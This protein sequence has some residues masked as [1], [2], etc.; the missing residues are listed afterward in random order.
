MRNL[1]FILCL[2]LMPSIVSAG[3]Y[4][5]LE[6]EFFSNGLLYCII[7]NNSVSVLGRGGLLDYSGDIVVPETVEYQGKE[8]KVKKMENDAF[9]SYP[10]IK[11]VYIGR[12][13]SEIDNFWFNFGYSDNLVSVKVDPNNEKYDSREDC[14]AIIETATNELI[15]GCP[16]TKIVSSIKTISSNAFLGVNKLKKIIIPEGVE[17]IKTNSFLFCNDLESISISKTVNSIGNYLFAKCNNLTSIIIDPDNPYYDSRDNCNA[18]INKQKNELV[19]GCYNSFIP[20][21]VK[22]ICSDA[23]HDCIKLEKIVI[24]NSVE[25]IEMQAFMGC[26]NLE[27]I[28]FG[29]SVKDMGLNTRSIFSR[30][31]R[32][33]HIEVSKENAFYDSRDDCNALIETSSNKIV[34]GCSS[35]VIPNSIKSIGGAAFIKDEYLSE[36]YIPNGVKTICGSAF[37]GCPKLTCVKIGRDVDDIQDLAF[38]E[39]PNLKEFYIDAKN[40]PQIYNYESYYFTFRDT[41]LSNV[42]LYVPDSSIDLYKNTYPWSEFKE[43]IGLSD[44]PSTLKS[45]SVENNNEYYSI[46][47]LRSM[48]PHKGIN[49]IRNNN[50]ITK[51]M[52]S[53]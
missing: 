4:T 29:S 46:N 52:I 14:N 5:P 13:V 50:G 8:Y 47:G 33:K 16:G 2:I 40:P 38:A 23:F 19:A 20:D 9:S 48:N 6:N 24:P 31:N 42:T 51:K 12:N 26:E 41:N 35:T 39:C 11:S 30:C 17:I 28:S 27:S 32:L 45:P 43:I 10:N 18:I 37:D 1:I 36:I 49:I 7:D 53:R 3:G 21:G 15:A 44:T 34:I 22:T 25:N